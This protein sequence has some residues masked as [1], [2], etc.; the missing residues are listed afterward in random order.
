MCAS[1]GTTSSSVS[2]LSIGLSENVR[3]SK[4]KMCSSNRAVSA[5]HAVLPGRS[6]K[7]PKVLEPVPWMNTSAGFAA[8]ASSASR[9][10]FLSQWSRDSSAVPRQW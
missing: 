7:L 1:A 5:S 4:P 9:A 6:P 10:S 8:T 2:A 3:C